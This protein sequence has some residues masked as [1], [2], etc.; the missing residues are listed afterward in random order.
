[1][2]NKQSTS[3]A[4]CTSCTA[5]FM[6]PA[7]FEKKLKARRSEYTRAGGIPRLAPVAATR[8]STKE[9]T[10]LQLQEHCVP[11]WLMPMTNAHG[12][13]NYKREE[14][15]MDPNRDFPYLQ[16]PQRCMQTQTARAVNDSWL[17]PPGSCG[18]FRAVCF[19][20]AISQVGSI[21]VLS[22]GI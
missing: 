2:D 10:V 13:A 21:E 16:M 3:K 7:D 20:T 18:K 17:W 11:R 15:G 1:M 8:C 5:D 22:P 14:N 4:A 19:S 6:V 12:Y 9:P